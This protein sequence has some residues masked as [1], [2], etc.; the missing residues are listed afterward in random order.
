MTSSLKKALCIEELEAS[1]SNPTEAEDVQL[2]LLRE[3]DSGG[4]GGSLSLVSSEKVLG[5]STS[6][7]DITG[8]TGLSAGDDTAWELKRFSIFR[9]SMGVGRLEMLSSS[10]GA[11]TSM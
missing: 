6:G 2:V 4:A 11:N 3:G 7:S 10:N 9:M 5:A 8:E 1:F